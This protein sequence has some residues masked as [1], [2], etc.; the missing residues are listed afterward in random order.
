MGIFD[1][2][3]DGRGGKEGSTGR[4]RGGCWGNSLLG[5]LKNSYVEFCVLCIQVLKWRTKKAVQLRVGSNCPEEPVMQSPALF[6]ILVLIGNRG[7]TLKD[8]TG[9]ACSQ[10]T[11]LFA[12][13]SNVFPVPTSKAQPSN[14]LEE[15]ASCNQ[16][17]LGLL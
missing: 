17:S 13:L 16:I 15:I 7:V 12:V 10:E 11:P 3:V 9:R 6:P 5:D 14:F 8:R 1:S 2:R 4:Q